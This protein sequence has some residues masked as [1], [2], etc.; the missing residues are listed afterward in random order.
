[1]GGLLLT[2]GM[3]RRILAFL[4]LVLAASLPFALMHHVGEGY[5]NTALP[6]SAVL[7][8]IAAGRL[9]PLAWQSRLG[10]GMTVVVLASFLLAHSHA[11]WSKGVRMRQ[12]GKTAY[13]LLERLETHAQRVPNGG[14]MVLCHVASEDEIVYSTYNRPGFLLLGKNSILGT[15]LGRRDI[16]VLV[17]SEPLSL[18][19]G[20]VPGQALVLTDRD[21][22]IE[23]HQ[24]LWTRFMEGQ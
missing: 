11:V 13:R 18:P 9:L 3:Q 14:S 5:V 4:L 24:I 10:R 6:F 16:D 20:I 8:G 12:N 2:S 7:V 19:P 15:L 1:V 22:V 17:V 23:Q 21:G